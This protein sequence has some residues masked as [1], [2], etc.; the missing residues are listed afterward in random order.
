M[1]TGK[2]FVLVGGEGCG[3]TTCMTALR[4][5]LPE[6]SFVFSREPG[7]TPAAEAVRDI[8]LTHEMT[9]FEQLLGFELAR[10]LHFRQK[11]KPALD[12][13]T[14]V[15]LDRCSESTWGY[16]MVAGEAGDDL[17]T[18]FHTLEQH[19]RHGVP[20][21]VWIDFQVDVET[22]LARRLS[23]GAQLNVFDHKTLAFHERVRE[24]LDEFLA[25]QTGAVEKVDASAPETQVHT[26]VAKIIARHM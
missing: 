4:E 21:D 11:V 12:A 20:V 6:D 16:Q 23:D 2:L 25:T 13:G 8:V 3:K 7:G 15:V 26:S 22:A 1:K 19:S 24:G 17:R 10:S 5:L 18:L 14:H 9:P